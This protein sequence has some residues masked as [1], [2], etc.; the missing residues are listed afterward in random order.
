MPLLE[1][2][3]ADLRSAQA[4]ADGGAQRIELCRDLHLDGLTPSDD[5]IRQARQ[6]AGLRLH[7]LIRPREG[8]FVY[9]EAEAQLMVQQIQQ[10]RRLGADGVVIGALTPQG[11]IDLPLCRRLIEAA[12]A[13]L[14]TDS[15]PGRPAAPAAPV[16]I[17]FHRA[18]DHCRRPL[19]ALEHIISLGCHRLLTSGQCVTA[20][21][22]IPLLRQ[23]VSQAAGR[24]IIMPGAGVSAQNARHILD[25]TGAT[26]IHGSLRLPDPLSGI[27]FTEPSLV[28]QLLDSLS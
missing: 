1:V 9:T 18:F 16:A 2:C 22:G 6:I 15:G 8:D 27:K 23:L 14:L 21:A 17:T 13:P 28:R 24:I 26:E 11:D 25:A 3:C 20:E 5:M 7:I 10:A 19:E 12:T 4:A